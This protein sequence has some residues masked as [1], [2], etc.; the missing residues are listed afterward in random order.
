MGVGSLH[1][2]DRVKD[3]RERI[4]VE[5]EKVALFL[6]EEEQ[7]LLQALKR[8]EEETAVQLRDSKAT[9]DQQRRSLDLLLMQL[10]D[11]SLREPVQMLQVRSPHGLCP[12]MRPGRG[13]VEVHRMGRKNAAQQ[14]G[15]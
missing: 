7:R 15:G 11:Q 2:Q 9:L 13:V 8:E 6:A 5:F 4:M 3:R 10:E 12:R 14:K 1:S